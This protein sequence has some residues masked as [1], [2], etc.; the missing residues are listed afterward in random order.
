MTGAQES[1]LAI[2]ASDLSADFV[3]NLLAQGLRESLTLEYK[4]ELSPRVIETVAAMTNSYGGLILIGISDKLEVVGVPP[5]TEMKL[6]NQCHNSLEPPAAPDMA[7]IDGVGESGATVL[8]VRVDP[9]RLPRPIVLNG[10]VLVRLHGRNGPA[11]RT[12]MFS[13]FNAQARSAPTGLG[14]GQ[15]L[16]YSPSRSYPPPGMNESSC[17]VLRSMIRV[18]RSAVSALPPVDTSLRTELQAR[19]A[20]SSLVDWRRERVRIADKRSDAP[21]TVR[22]V[23]TST[24]A[25][26]VLEPPEADA[27]V[28]MLRVIFSLPAPALGGSATFLLDAVFTSGEAFSPLGVDVVIELCTLMLHDIVSGVGLPFLGELLG[29]GLWME[30]FTETRM[31]CSQST[32]MDWFDLGRFERLPDAHDLRE[33]SP[34]VLAGTAL[35]REPFRPHVVDWMKLL[36]LDFGIQ[37]FRGK[38]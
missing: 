12:R 7:I 10:K 38:P 22:G 20:V 11:D 13:L 3:E 25:S 36:L 5:D 16:G 6:V 9:N 21:W 1:M 33:S 2:S 37:S 30:G 29:T 19:L 18:Q 4:Q 14:G 17:L 34:L 28:P 24:Q 27:Y 23:N 15:S 8:A 31:E 35:Q 26:F 32:F